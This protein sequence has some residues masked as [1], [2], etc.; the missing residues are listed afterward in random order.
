MRADVR[1]IGGRPLPP[2]EGRIF[3]VQKRS[4]PALRELPMIGTSG[5]MDDVLRSGGG[6]TWL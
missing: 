6:L 4:V 2:A 3:F 5:R 1:Q